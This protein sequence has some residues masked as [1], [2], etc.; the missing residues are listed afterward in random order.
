MTG[1]KKKPDKVT[2]IT[3]AVI[4]ILIL[5]FAA[6]FIWG[7]N[8]VLA[9]EGTMPP[10]ENAAS[11]TPAPES[12]SDGVSYL[13]SSVA[14]AVEGKPAFARRSEFEIDGDTI[15]TD[16]SK[17]LKD[18]LL[19]IRENIE[20]YLNDNS[21]K[22]EK[23]YFEGF[24]KELRIPRISFA[25]VEDFKCDYIYYKCSS[26]DE[27]S[28]APLDKC[29]ACGSD[30]PYNELYRDEYTLTLT[31]RNTKSNVKDNFDFREG[32]DAV[33]ML[34]GEAK[35]IFS[36]NDISI[37]YDKLTITAQINRLT[38]EII[39]LEYK[40]DMTVKTV[41]EFKRDYAKLGETA[42]SFKMTQNDVYEFIWPSLVLSEE[43]MT[44][45]PK[46]S[47]NLLAALTCDD[48]LAYKVK[49]ES[50]DP[51]ILT[52]DEEGYF[53]AGKKTGEAAITASFEFGGK[54]YSDTCNVYVRYPVESIKI[55]DKKLNLNKGDT[56][57][58]S[59]D[60]S[61]KKATVKTVKWYTE[62]ESIASVDKNGTVT[63]VSSGTVKVYALSDDGY[64]KSTCE[65]KVK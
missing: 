44:V 61:P 48:P 33:A 50:S 13:R 35:K 64:Y 52:V 60:V 63:A 42:I 2:I 10:S 59:V 32:E 41:G 4:A 9:M 18:T 57:V 37:D 24:E 40:K 45:E 12:I 19:Y 7:L 54:S 22:Y 47:D 56:H 51:E 39:S 55:S 21:E 29:D 36:V 25:D 14:K 65:V 11:L 3:V 38:D 8:N 16:G 30:N 46:K 6:G 62:D 53:K 58:L 23:K 27:E 20:D 49:W 43:K 5:T 26:C 1:N 31:I 15:E 28:D 34:G 17:Q